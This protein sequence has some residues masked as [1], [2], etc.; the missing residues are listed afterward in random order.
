[1]AQAP[2]PKMARM[3]RNSRAARMIVDSL[4]A[5]FVPKEA[6]RSAPK[7]AL[8]QH[9]GRSGPATV[10][11]PRR[12]EVVARA[13]CEVSEGRQKEERGRLAVVGGPW[14]RVA[15]VS[16]RPGFSLKNRCYRS[17]RWQ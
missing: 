8:R 10:R 12:F 16:R 7:P 6:N 5:S 1:M 13:N 15:E 17:R 9:C 3:V 11:R 14:R 4:L 2:M